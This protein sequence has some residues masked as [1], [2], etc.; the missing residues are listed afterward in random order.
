MFLSVLQRKPSATFIA[1]SVTLIR[2]RISKL[3]TL[4]YFDSLDLVFN[5]S[6]YTYRFEV[7]Y[8]LLTDCMRVLPC[9][10]HESCEL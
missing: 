1:G 10:K 3:T 5:A 8:F 7:Y 9:N 4:Q 2:I 6:V